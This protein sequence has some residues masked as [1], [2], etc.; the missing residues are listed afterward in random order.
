MRHPPGVY[1]IR[2]GQTK[3]NETGRHT[4]YT[5]I[6]LNDV[7]VLQAKGIFDRLKEK[8]ILHVF[9]SPMS[10]AIDTCVLA[11]LGEKMHITDEL[12]EWNYGRYEGL[13]TEEI[14][15]EIKGWK[16]FSHGAKEGETVAQVE[17]RARRFL[18][19]IRKLEGDVALFSHGH[20]S[21]VLAA[22]WIGLGANEG[23]LFSLS[24]ATISILSYEREES[25]IQV[26]NDSSHHQ[27]T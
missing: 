16:I 22:V 4:S 19:K 11:G 5:D 6:P 9:S 23:S 25:V 12:S 13:T 10:R 27:S 21:R 18:E 1:L 14:R 20:F 24:N 17:F 15:K 3:W 7:G 2:H 8:S 26:W